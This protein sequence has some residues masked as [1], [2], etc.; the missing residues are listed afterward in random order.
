MDPSKLELFTDTNA[1]K[2]ALL[3]NFDKEVQLLVSVA[4]R[5]FNDWNFEQNVEARRFSGAVTA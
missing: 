4:V 5:K 1:H 3:F 2:L